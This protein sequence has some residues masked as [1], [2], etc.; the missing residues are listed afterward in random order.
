MRQKKFITEK[1]SLKMTVKVLVAAFFILPSSLFISSCADYNETDNFTAQ[2]DPSIQEPYKDL[3]PV[4]SYI[5]RDAY[6]NMSLRGLYSC[7]CR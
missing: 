7:S 3:K 2:A 6:P 5:N 1:R 4:K